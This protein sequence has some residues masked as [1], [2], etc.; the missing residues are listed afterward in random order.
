MFAEATPPGSRLLSVT[1]TGIPGVDVWATRATDGTVRV[2]LTNEGSGARELAVHMPGK[3]QSATLARLT[4]PSATATSGVT[5]AGQ[6][7]GSA[8]TTGRLAGSSQR[9]SA[10]VS[11]D[12]GRYEIALP[13]TSA[14]MLV[15][16]PHTSAH[17]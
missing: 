11:G 3:F 13:P 9:T 10:S 2:V 12:D 5:L 7:F 6:S 15:L 17:R 8:T 14:A 1:P 4:A 16:S